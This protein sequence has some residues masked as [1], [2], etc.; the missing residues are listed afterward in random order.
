MED[1]FVCRM[2]MWHVHTTQ[3]VIFQIK[4]RDNEKVHFAETFA[5]KL[6]TLNM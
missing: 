1:H 4:S 3:K 5:Y 6:Y 2:D